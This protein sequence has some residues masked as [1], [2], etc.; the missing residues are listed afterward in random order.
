MSSVYADNSLKKRSIRA[1]IWTSSELFMRQGLQ[2]GVA[3]FLARLLSPEEF[4][5]VALLALFI[6][7]GNVFIESGFSSAL[8]QKQDI[9]HADESTVFWFNS[10]MGILVAVLLW[11]VAP[12]IADFYQR[13]VLTPLM[14]VMALSVFISAIGGIQHTLLTKNLNFKAPMQASV[15]GSLLSGIV[16]CVL[17]YYGY[18]V[19]ALA[20]QTLTYSAV[21]SSLLWLMSSWRPSLVF[22]IQSLKKMF[23]FGGYLMLTSLMDVTYNRFY[24][25]LIGKVYS[26]HDLGIYNR[27][28][29]T[30]QIPADLLAL[31][32]YRV[33]FPLF[34]AAANDHERL[35]RGV[36]IALRGIMFL[37]VPIMLGLMVTAD[38]VV[39]VLF[40]EQWTPAVPLLQVLCLAGLFWP[41]QAINLNVLKA[42]G[43]S[44]LFFRLEVIKKVL[45]TL[46]ILGGLYFGTMGLAWSQVIFSVVAFGIN[47]FY[48]GKYLQYGVWNQI[49]DFLPATI[50][51]ITMAVAVFYAGQVINLSTNHLLL[52]QVALGIFVYWS[53]CSVCRITAYQDIMNVLMKRKIA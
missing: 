45:G 7:I 19:W 9:S 13:P 39:P 44:H 26:I 11:L 6:G 33:A 15:A 21:T 16:V 18:S 46:L 22:S 24:A 25:L 4:G 37:N 10:G 30:K 47:T 48:T 43:H 20:W 32:V 41:L 49:L 36:V 50:I 52:A 53:L 28:E 42:L 23:G 12:L 29:N 34:S 38:K 2:F 8:V 35:K 1:L 14:G 17:A 40:G 27:A 3:I 51:S 31:L 5:T